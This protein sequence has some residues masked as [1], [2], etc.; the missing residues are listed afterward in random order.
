MVLLTLV[1]IVLFFDLCEVLLE[2]IG[3]S[4]WSLAL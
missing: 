3:H 2:A 1:H 4:I